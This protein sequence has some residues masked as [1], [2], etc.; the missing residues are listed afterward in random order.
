MSYNAGI[1]SAEKFH[2][3]SI[4]KVKIVNAEQSKPLNL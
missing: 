3:A 2:D 1:K 4:K